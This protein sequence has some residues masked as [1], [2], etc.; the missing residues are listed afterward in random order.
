MPSLGESDL[1]IDSRIVGK[2]RVESMHADPAIYPRLGMTLRCQ[3][4]DGK[5]DEYTTRTP[6]VG[7]KLR[8]LSGELRLS[9]HG[10]AIG[11]VRWTGQ[12]GDVASTRYLHEH[13]LALVCD[14]DPWRIESI[15][16]RRKGEAPTFWLEIWP[17]IVREGQQLI[18]QLQPIRLDVPRDQWLG[19]L[20]R[21]RHG[22]FEI[23]EIP[24]P[25]DEPE[26]FKRALE[27]TKTARLRIDLGDYDEAVGNCRKAIEVVSQCFP[28]RDGEEDGLQGA[29]AERTDGRRA[30]EYVGIIAR[31]KQLAGFAHH[32]LGAGGVEYSRVEAQFLVRTTECMLALV[33]KLTS[34]DGIGTK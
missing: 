25:S 7:F 20:G 31:L 34:S 9:Q 24:F 11:S 12:R 29:L 1:M 8:D 21:V 17:S 5:Q 23:L 15:E 28:K 26:A 27:H 30:K 10:D 13:H 3:L 19:F 2:F 6:L 18:S 14:L 32:D 22:R 4:L 33:G 16:E